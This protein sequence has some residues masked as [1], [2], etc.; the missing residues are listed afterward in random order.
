MHRENGVEDWKLDWENGAEMKEE[1]KLSCKSQ[2]INDVNYY[3]YYK[4]R[5]ELIKKAIEQHSTPRT[6]VNKIIDW[7]PKKM[8]WGLGSFINLTC[9]NKLTADYRYTN[10]LPLLVQFINKGFINILWDLVF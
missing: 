3:S 4:I 1:R 7:G 5:T 6:D 8:E 9:I 10:Y 2:I